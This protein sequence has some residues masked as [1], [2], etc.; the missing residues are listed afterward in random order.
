MKRLFSVDAE[1]DVILQDDTFMLIPELRKVYQDKKLGSDAIKWIV[2]MT[3]YR[4]P[5]RQLLEDDRNKDVTFD[6]YGKTQ[7]KALD[8]LLVKEARDKYNRL[9]Y[10]PLIDQYAVYT[11][12]IAEYNRF[13]D[14]FQIEAA[15]ALDLNKL[16]LG[17]EKVNEAREKIKDLIMKKEEEEQISGGGDISFL[18]ATVSHEKRS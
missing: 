17:N 4:S 16:M 11:K 1:G 9:Q 14:E 3:D 18:E 2:L 6:V 15:T 7:H 5:Y 12:K 8:C 13:I 10:D